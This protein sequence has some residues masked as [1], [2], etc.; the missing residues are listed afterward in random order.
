MKRKT[1]ILK[2]CLFGISLF[3]AVGC[4]SHVRELSNGKLRL[5]LREK[6]GLLV[7]NYY[8]AAAEGWRLMVSV[9]G[10]DKYS[11]LPLY[12]IRTNE[13]SRYLLSHLKVNS[14][15]KEKNESVEAFRI[16]GLVNN[17]GVV[18]TIALGK[19]DD[20]FQIEVETDLSRSAKVEYI[21]S[22]FVFHS[23]TTRPEFIHTPALKFHEDDIIGDRTFWQPAIVLQ[24][25]SHL[26]ALA[27][28]LD[29]INRHQTPVPGA[30]PT[31]TG[32]NFGIPI[33][34]S[35][36]TF[37]TGFDLRTDLPDF[38]LFSY[39]Y[40]DAIA[41]QH[42]Y[43]SHPNNSSMVRTVPAPVLKYGFD[44]ILNAKANRYFGY[45]QVSDYLWEKYGSREFSLGKNL[46]M[47]LEEYA[48]LCYEASKNYKG[49]RVAEKD[50][51]VIALH[52]AP[53]QYQEFD[54]WLEWEMNGIPVGGYRNNAPQWYDMVGNTAWWN[55]A[56]DAVGMFRWGKRLGDSSLVDRGRRAVNLALQAPQKEGVFPVI[57][58]YRDKK[59]IG[60]HWEPPMSLDSSR[61]ARYFDDEADAYHTSSMSKTAV[62]LLR[63][64][65]YCEQRDEIIPF[66]ERYAGFLLKAIDSEGCIPSFFNG[67]LEPNP[68][69]QKN[70]AGGVHLW[71]LAVLYQA[72]GKEAYLDG[73]L[74]VASYLQNQ[75]I[76]YQN[77]KDY[78]AYFSCGVKPLNFFDTYTGQGPRNTLSMYWSLEG[79]LSLFEAT[80]D[81]GHLETA[82]SVADYL[83][84]YQAVWQPH[85]ITTAYAFGGFGVQNT[86]AEWLD[87]RQGEIAPA[88]VR[89]GVLTGRKDY[90]ERGIAAAKSSLILVHHERHIKNNIYSY[91]NFPP[92]LGPENIDH[93]GRP[94]SPMRTNAGW[95]EV[96]GLAGI[97]DVLYQIGDLYIDVQN[98]FAVG[99]NGIRVASFQK[100]QHDVVVDIENTLLGLSFPYEEEITIEAKAAP[101]S[102]A[103]QDIDI[104]K[105]PGIFLKKVEMANTGI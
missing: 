24:Q 19:D 61:V 49:S 33:D 65:L 8:A 4:S 21:L 85:F 20:R 72:T 89:L 93:E 79:F 2:L 87:A 98:E 9:N 44:L 25:G 22:D 60:N 59:W 97:A 88:L 51:K 41:S 5:E 96:S 1:T 92:G 29:R 12:D 16:E 105:G 104:K 90:I 31:A 54:S 73:A 40:I 95:G 17:A 81:P 30:R 84:F 58:R 82:A 48:R 83:S 14:I 35:K 37:P 32:M 57:F 18:M 23:D 63:Y 80:R 52:T 46:A 75:V 45:R 7:Q 15:N 70:G 78:E 103:L 71:F 6:D 10:N 100:D 62:H 13:G 74:K 27:P 53:D 34:S 11:H 56:R 42:M 76:P 36:I 67:D 26:V 55:N 66:A 43:W 3:F 28:D 39:G 94:Q 69:L 91:P 102:G 99:V 101:G 38:S 50:G 77:W 68:H 47:P 86:D 64:Y